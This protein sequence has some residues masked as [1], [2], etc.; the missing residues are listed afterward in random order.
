[1]IKQLNVF[2]ICNLTEILFNYKYTSVYLLR[3]VD[4]RRSLW[5]SCQQYQALD[6]ERRQLVRTKHQHVL[7]PQT[8][9][10]R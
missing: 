7:C 8:T 10:L 2:A 5:S 3:F 6:P 4:V 1:M 9:R